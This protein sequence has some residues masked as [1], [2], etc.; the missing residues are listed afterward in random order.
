[1]SRTA[2][3]IMARYPEV[4]MVKTRLARAIGAERA[5]AL[6]HAF[7]RDLDARFVRGS[8]TLIWAFHPPERDFAT[9]VSAAS[10][11]EPQVGGTLGERM[12]NGFLKLC[13]EFA[14]VLMI[15][16]DVPHV[17]DAWLDEA[18]RTLDDA[19]IVLGPSTDGGYYLIG[20]RDP[21]DVFAGVEMS[22]PRVLAD[23][24]RIAAARALRVHQLP[25]TFDIDEV[26]DFR[27]LHELL[28]RDAIAERLPATA[29][30][31]RAWV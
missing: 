24:C 19:D 26:T 30:L 31:L 21:H 11:C 5:H 27:R 25:A 13:R 22:T 10:R 1:M 15:G 18:E 14:R 23:T 29:A 4:G 28:Q 16:A 8:R 3:V 9:L 7:L 6:Y 2:L 12:H 20:M 17:E